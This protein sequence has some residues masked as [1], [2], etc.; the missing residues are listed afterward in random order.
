MNTVKLAPVKEEAPI[1]EV[2]DGKAPLSS[3]APIDIA[4][5]RKKKAPTPWSKFKDAQKS[6]SHGVK[7]A[8]AS[9]PADGAG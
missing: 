3:A 2:K 1:S 4:C 8:P 7:L 5:D 6:T 9:E